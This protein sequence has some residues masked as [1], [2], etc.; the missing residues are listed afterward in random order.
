MY[1]DLTITPTSIKQ[2]TKDTVKEIKSSSSIKSSITFEK[3]VSKNYALN[4]KQVEVSKNLSDKNVKYLVDINILENGQVIKISD[5]KMKIKI[6]LPEDLKG[7][8][9]YE[10]VYIL[11][12]EIKETI[13]ATIEDGNI[14][15]ETSHLSQYGIVSKELTSNT[16]I[17]NPKTVDNII[18]YFII[19]IVSLTSLIVLKKKFN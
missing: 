11:N 4:I 12:D 10:I 6:A 16:N 7:Y 5:T 13:P 1:P 14:V 17:E 2:P 8:K 18:Y 19:C 9:E 3:E 15:F